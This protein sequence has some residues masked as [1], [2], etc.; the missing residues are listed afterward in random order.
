M[1]DFSNERAIETAGF[2]GF[3][4][5]KNL[6]SP[7][8][9]R[10]IA[11]Q[12][13]VY[14]VLRLAE[15][16]PVFLSVG[17]VN[18]RLIKSP[19]TIIDLQTKWNRINGTV[20]VYIGKATTTLHKRLSPFLRGANNHMGGRAIWQLEDSTELLFCW[21]SLENIDASTYEL[22]L[23]ASFKAKYGSYPFANWRA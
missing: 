17:S 22:Q 3:I 9:R 4:P 13:G 19:Y 12:A 18:N 16:A 7:I 20:V 6:Q 10:Q 8:Q 15:T 2:Q 14:M 11:N 5:V 1:L 23:L 21:K